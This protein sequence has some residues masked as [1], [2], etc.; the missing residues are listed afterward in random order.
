MQMTCD[1]RIDCDTNL[2]TN[3]SSEGAEPYPPFYAVVYPPPNPPPMDQEFSMAGCLFLC[4]SYIS[5]EDANNCAL[6]QSILCTTPPGEEIWYSAPASCT[7]TCPDGGEFTYTVPAGMFIAKTF[8]EALAQAQAYA[9]LKAQ[10]ERICL[11]D[12]PRC[13]CLGEHYSAS[14]NLTV[15]NAGVVFGLAGILPPGLQFISSGNSAVITGVPT[16]NG[17]YAFN[18]IATDTNG[19]YAIRTYVIQ[20]VQITTSALPDFTIGT[21][22]SFQLQAAGGSGNYFWSV[23]TGSL[24]DGLA[25]S[26]SGLISGTP[27]PSAIGGTLTFEVRDATC[28]AAQRVEITPALAMHTSSS[29]RVLTY[30]GFTEYNTLSQLGQLYKRVDYAGSLTQIAFPNFNDPAVNAVQCAGM[31]F[32]YSGFDQIDNLGNILN[33]HRKD[34]MVMCAASQPSIFK[35][36]VG[37]GGSANI[38]PSFNPAALYGYCWPTDPESCSTCDTNDTTWNL[39]RDDAWFGAIDYPNNMVWDINNVT[40]TPTVLTYAGNAGLVGGVILDPT[41][42]GFPKNS[43]QGLYTQGFPFV[44]LQ[45][46]GGFSATLSEP[47]TDADAN[48]TAVIYTG[49]S[50]TAENTPNYQITGANHFI[51]RRSR[52]TT[53]SFSIMCTN[54]VIGEEYTVSYELVSSSGSGSS[55]V[56]NFT[57]D[58]TTH[59][60]TGLIPTPADNLKTTIRNP[61][62]RYA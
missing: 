51:T 8:A 20:V 32:I 37:I 18:V 12:L 5:Q 36:E 25:L 21:P 55:Q 56:V 7:A 24:P 19:N 41:I 28:E 27:T 6:R 4:K 23:A 48:A 47:F 57:A 53:V 59:E 3:Y 43:G 60:I 42:Q 1:K 31:Q 14:I 40:F 10:E 26:L 16:V 11:G 17:T 38:T 45:S 13:A 58:A 54:L 33:R 61:R 39:F 34:M 52:I 2:L 49:T 9:C 29:T 30:R 22:Y 15:P 44:R 50:A 46:N 62:I 35:I